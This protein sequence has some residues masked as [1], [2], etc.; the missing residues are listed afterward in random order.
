M[1]LSSAKV[2]LLDLAIF[3]VSKV[4]TYFQKDFLSII[5]L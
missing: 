3:S 1:E 5:F 2:I 4:L